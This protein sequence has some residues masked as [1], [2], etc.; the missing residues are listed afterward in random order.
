LIVGLAFAGP[1]SFQNV[2]I[3]NNAGQPVV[4]IVVG[5]TAAPSDGV[6]AANIAAV[7]GNLAYTST[8]ITATVNG[9]NA[10]SCAVTTPTCTLSNQQVWLG[11][12]G[13]VVPTGSYKISTLIGSIMNGGVLNYN[14]LSSTKTLD[15]TGTYSYPE[16]SSPYPISTSPTASVFTGIT[17]YN[18]IPVNQSVTAGTN[19]GGMNFA[20]FSDYNSSKKLYYDNIV[21]LSN[22]QVP[23]LMSSSGPNSE[24]EYL[25]LMGFPVYDQA[26]NNFALL[27]ANGAY[28]VT[29]G[30]PVPL[31]SGTAP[32][33]KQIKFLGENWTIYRGITPTGSAPDSSHYAVGGKLELAQSITPQETVYVG[34]NITS[35]PI[36]VVL[37]DLSYPTSN[38][39]SNAAIAVYNKGVL[40]NETSIAPGNIYPINSSGDA[41]AL[42]LLSCSYHYIVCDNL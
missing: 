33:Y 9:K 30:A 6:V 4:Q 27:D 15:N 5:S 32:A 16:E 28:Q 36:T 39:I 2:P 26:L 8:P 37:Q 11:E 29:F 40:T 42:I 18:P 41:K 20:K 19:G 25:W 7:I 3:I 38:G 35:G 31:Y 12:K 10:V 1:V 17:S 23:G 13:V 34:H 14:T 21:E 24:S 22:A